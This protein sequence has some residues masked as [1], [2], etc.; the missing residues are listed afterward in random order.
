MSARE[1]KLVLNKKK[2]NGRKK[3]PKSGAAKMRSAADKAMGQAC[4][5]IVESLAEKGQTGETPSAEILYE[6]A[7]EAEELAEGEGAGSFRNMA[8]ELAN[9]PEWK[10]DSNG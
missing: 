4:K 10:G 2:T 5:R 8:L 1:K 9:L 7:H 3:K 6:L